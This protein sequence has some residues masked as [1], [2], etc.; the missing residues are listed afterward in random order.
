MELQA[1]IC[2]QCGAQLEV[3]SVTTNLTVCPKCGSSIH[4]TYKSGENDKG[5]KDFVTP[6]G[7]KVG[8][9]RVADKYVLNASVNDRWQSELVPFTARASANCEDEIIMI[10]D[11][12]ELFHDVKSL[13]IKGIIGLVPNHTSNGYVSFF[14]PEDYLRDYAEKISSAKLTPVAKAQLP[15]YFGKNPEVAKTQLKNDIA[16]FDAFMEIPSSPINTLCESV[17]YKY[18]GKTASGVDCVVYAGMDYEGE[19]LIYGGGLFKGLDTKGIKDNLTKVMENSKNLSELGS[20]VS[21][22]LKGKDKLTFSDMMSGGLIGKAMRKSKEKEDKKPEE[23]PVE[24]P[25]QEPK[26]EAPAVFGHSVRRVDQITFGA[27]RKYICVA[28]KE[29]EAEAERDFLDFVMTFEPSQALGQRQKEMI[30]Q[31]MFQI[32]QA[33]AQNQAIVMQKQQQLHAM[34]MQTSQMISQNARQT[35]AGI[36]D[37]WNKK[38]AS[39]SRISQARSEANLGVNTYQNSYGQNVQVSVAADHVYQNQYGDVY[40]VSGNAPDQSVLNDLNWTELKKK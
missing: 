6:D 14:E 16:A 21:D 25:L 22:V 9:A 4:I 31:K 35:S 28:L 24:E 17:L 39:D 13:M 29:R 36:M 12:K 40:G 19:E 26:K 30:D 33:V 8:S 15:S 1:F 18:E 34:Q 5:L 10:S 7:L 20:T 3:D 32:R 37:S 23:K 11:S 2:P 27:Y 38:M